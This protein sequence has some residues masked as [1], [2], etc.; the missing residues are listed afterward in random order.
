[1][2]HAIIQSRTQFLESENLHF[3]DS[4]F[5]YYFSLYDLYLRRKACDTGLKSR[6]LYFLLKPTLS[7]SS[8]IVGFFLIS[9]Q[10]LYTNSKN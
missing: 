6:L 2:E 4:Y 5:Q 1:M 8:T 7:I 9:K 10:P 3:C